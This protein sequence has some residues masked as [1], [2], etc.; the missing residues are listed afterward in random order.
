M[1]YYMPRDAGPLD[2]QNYSKSNYM[3][4]I[5]DNQWPSSEGIR[6][7][8]QPI[9]DY[10]YYRDGRQEETSHSIENRQRIGRNPNGSMDRNHRERLH[11]SSTGSPFIIHQSSMEFRKSRLMVGNY[12]GAPSYSR[13]ADDAGL[14]LRKDEYQSEG[15]RGY[16]NRNIDQERAQSGSKEASQRKAPAKEYLPPQVAKPDP[17]NYHRSGISSQARPIVAL[18]P[19]VSPVKR[20]S[21]HHAYFQ[22]QSR[23]PQVALQDR[24]PQIR[25][26]ASNHL[27]QETNRKNMSHEHHHSLY[28]GRP[29]SQTSFAFD[30]EERYSPKGYQSPQSP[31]LR[32]DSR[33]AYH[34]LPQT[35]RSYQQEG[36]AHSKERCHRSTS[37]PVAA[38][39]SSPTQRYSPKGIT[40][41]YQGKAE[42]LIKSTSSPATADP[43]KKRP[44]GG[45]I[46]S[47]D[48]EL[49]NQRSVNI[50]DLDKV[51]TSPMLANVPVG[52]V[53]SPVS[54][55]SRTVRKT[56]DDKVA[57]TF[58][59]KISEEKEMPDVIGW[60]KQPNR[61][62]Q[63][64]V[65]QRDARRTHQ[66]VDPGHEA[67]K[68]QEGLI[69]N[70]HS[71]PDRYN[72]YEHHVSTSTEKLYPGAPLGYERQARNNNHP[73]NCP[74]Q[75][76]SSDLRS[77]IRVDTTVSDHNIHSSSSNK[78]TSNIY[79]GNKVSP[80]R[81]YSDS[82]QFSH[83]QMKPLQSSGSHPHG[84]DFSQTPPPKPPRRHQSLNRIHIPEDQDEGELSDNDSYKEWQNSPLVGKD[85]G[86]SLSG[87][88]DRGDRERNYER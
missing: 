5:N 26:P 32:N 3:R 52:K 65:S 84:L 87:R 21:N 88:S 75:R 28:R 40:K 74:P 8:H 58:N 86:S 48:I 24:S 72:S 41:D 57:R 43:R 54:P 42:H 64:A 47:S 81:R 4:D 67:M 76:T 19:D 45:S 34:G 30:K 46:T 27:S 60:E 82:P 61:Q 38:P 44:S 51:M 83:A 20:S 77:P 63:G 13:S 15:S 10:N 23:S 62:K 22:E 80:N 18:P 17:R 16:G 85:I 70:I 14:Y 33:Q 79:P 12:Q 49:K 68:A 55:D 59:F 78:K 50:V 39:L 6:Q 9:D 36:S 25:S 69:R 53:T 73:N 1:D 37:S 31:S 11:Q 71:S 66:N 56:P 7:Y 35:Q 2:N 29:D